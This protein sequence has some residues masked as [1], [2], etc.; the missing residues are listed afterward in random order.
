MLTCSELS[1]RSAASLWMRLGRLVPGAIRRLDRRMIQPP[2]LDQ[3]SEKLQVLHVDR[4]GRL[5]KH[6][7]IAIEA[8]YIP[9]AAHIGHDAP[10]GDSPA[11]HQRTDA[12]RVTTVKRGAG[13]S[14]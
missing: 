11:L 9:K 6:L 10:L 8:G 12:V 1:C 3:P 13:G 4:L 2:V 7:Q 5:A 14:V